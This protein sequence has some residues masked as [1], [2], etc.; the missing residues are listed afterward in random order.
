MGN[1][2]APVRRLASSAA[3]LALAGATRAVAAV[4]TAGKP[5]HPRGR[6]VVGR[7][8]RTGAEPPTGVAWLD[9]TGDD[10]VLVRWSRAVGLPSPLPDIHGL[11]L[12]VPRDDGG[13]GDL[14]FATTGLGR[15]TRFVLTASGTPY[16]R[17]L[18]TLLPYRTVHGPLLLAAVGTGEDASRSSAPP[19][20][21]RGGT[22]PTSTCRTPRGRTRRS[23]ST[24][25]GTPSPGWPPM[26]WSAGCGSRATGPL[27][28]P[29]ATDRK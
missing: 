19:R 27:A 1:V 28:G 3:G 8:R 17:P 7:L 21:D 25:C 6:V 5:L 13:H 18:T 11:A 24:R 4:R 16:G 2:A 22:S 10:E 14:L 9:E 20:R 29:G 12:R 26:T 23:P 15:L